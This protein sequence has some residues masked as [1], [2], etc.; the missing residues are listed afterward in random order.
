MILRT[1]WSSAP[2]GCNGSM[3][4][5]RCELHDHCLTHDEARCWH[6]Q[7]YAKN[8][9]AGRKL[10]SAVNAIQLFARATAG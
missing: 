2:G 5:A 7:Y 4:I 9:T 6:V 8:S 10:A 3:L 1:T